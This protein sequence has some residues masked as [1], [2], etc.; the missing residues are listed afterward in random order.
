MKPLP[1][2]VHETFYKTVIESLGLESSPPEE[3]VSAIL[4]LPV[5]EILSKIP[6]G[7]PLQPVVDGDVVPLSPSF[8]EFANKE[9]TTIPGKQWCEELLIGDN[10]LDVSYLSGKF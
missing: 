1:P 7:L 2:F 10:Q 3:R 8:S 6:P 9:A 5:D 4:T